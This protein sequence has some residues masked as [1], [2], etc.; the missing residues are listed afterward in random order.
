MS[1]GMYGTQAATSG[2]RPAL[3]GTQSPFPIGG[4][5]SMFNTQMQQLA[6][7]IPGLASQMSALTQTSATPRIRPVS[8]IEEARASAIDFDGSVF[9]F[10]DAANNRIYTKQINMDGTASL[11][12]YVLQ[13]IPTAPQP[14]Q[15]AASYVSKNEFQQTISL[16]LEEIN[17]M[18]EG[19]QKNDEQQYTGQHIQQYVSTTAQQQL[20]ATTTTIQPVANASE[21]KF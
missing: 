20:P 15:I 9:Y 11:N 12:M 10:T 13:D 3:A 4:Q 21:F 2:V 8:S 1:Y 19:E 5:M 6:S 17:K 18:K 7:Q 14:E 16:L